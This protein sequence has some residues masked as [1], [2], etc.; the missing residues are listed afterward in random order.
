MFVVINIKAKELKLCWLQWQAFLEVKPD[1]NTDDP[2][3]VIAFEIA[4]QTIG[5]FKLKSAETYRVPDDKRVSPAQ[6]Y[7]QMLCLQREVLQ[8]SSLLYINKLN[9]HWSSWL[10]LSSII[11]RHFFTIE[12]DWYKNFYKTSHIS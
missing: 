5:D 9:Q 12:F 1:I 11:C 6:K 10:Y 2:V 3:D 8:N 4:T 7:W